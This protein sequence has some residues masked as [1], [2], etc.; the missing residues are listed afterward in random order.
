M[1]KYYSSDK[2]T[3]GKGLEVGDLIRVHQKIY[4]EEKT[5]LQVFE[6]TVI[7]IKNRGTNKSITVRKMSYD[8]V[9]VERIWPLD[10]PH[11]DH[12]DIKKKGN[13]RRA[14]LYFLRGLK[15]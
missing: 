3:G 12:I 6:G 1:A 4:E 9:A 8:K 2:I 13:E 11:I 7:A 14:K 10:S 15:N 5:R